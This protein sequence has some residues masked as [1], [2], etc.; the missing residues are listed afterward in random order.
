MEDNTGKIAGQS[1]PSSGR[2]LTIATAGLIS[3]VLTIAMA[4]A[5][6]AL[7][8]S[9]PLSGYVSTGISLILFGAFVL[10]TV[11][12]LTS[13]YAGTVARPHEIPAAIVA[14]IAASIAGHMTAGASGG[15]MFATVIAAIFVASC[16][17]GIFFLILGYLNLGNL[18]RFVPYPVIGGF[19]AGTG[20][21]LVKGAFGVMTGR[22]LTIENITYLASFS[23]L[24]KWL[25][26]LAFALVLF[27][28]LRWRNHYLVMP[29]WLTISFI[30][31]YIVA[32][33]VGVTFADLR[34]GGWLIGSIESSG[35]RDLSLSTFSQID[36]GLVAAQTGK[37][38]TILILSC[39]SLLLN[40][41]GLEIVVKEDIDLN[42]ELR[43]TGFAN[44]LSGLAGST[45][46][47][48]SL[49]L[50]A[51]GYSMGAKS[52]MV[53]VISAFLCAS[54][55]LF[56]ASLLAYFPRPIMGG[57]LLFLGLTF[58]YEW[59]FQ[60]WSRLPKIDYILIVFIL[61]I[62]G[63]FGFLQGVAVGML[64][65]I[66]I[67][68]VK[69]SHVSVVKHS[70]SGVSFQSNVDRAPAQ[71]QVLSEKGGSMYILKLQGFIFFGTANDL[72]DRIRRRAND[73]TLQALRFAVLDFRL[74]NG[75]DSSAVNT[76]VKMRDQAG[77]AG[78]TLVFAQVPQEDLTL[79]RRGGFEP[80]D[81][82]S[83]RVFPD[84]DLAAE[85]CENEILLSENMLYDHEVYP[86]EERLRDLFPGDA[87]EIRELMEYAERKEV[88]AG[89]YLIRQNDPPHSLYYLESGRATVNLEDA[90]GQG[91]RLRTL[92]P[93]TIIGELGLYLRE[94]STASVVTE[95]QSVFYKITVDELQRMEKED[96]HLASAFHRF[97]IRQMG[98]R[99]I[100]TNLSLKAH[101]D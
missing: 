44:L 66:V 21:L 53:G 20:L 79:F 88:P 81:T 74:V 63:M 94:P 89:F 64:V 29:V 7:I 86:L 68:V 26:G 23:L 36:W 50:S 10:G 73:G 75:I 48:H 78:Y 47:F 100:Y 67:F 55:I 31:F 42:R 28:I 19:L 82:G 32:H 9:G 2:Y 18:I 60:T 25:P 87:G 45:V 30:L 43:S 92:G 85:W 12:A 57:V 22:A 6:S 37:I 15:A 8:F 17:T 40:A 49:S 35:A 39:V 97:I 99:L 93:G 101:L 46:G 62:I 84:L 4:C 3:G 95:T 65:A 83:F 69:Y 33:S 98:E 38:L 72:Y 56:G 16:A 52:R 13:S 71:K 14:I 24:I 90:S 91:V 1:A 80:G 27:F 34:A 58:L 54:I 70:L 51:L 5:F 41:S 96:P 77:A 61:V 76:F 59:L 11:T